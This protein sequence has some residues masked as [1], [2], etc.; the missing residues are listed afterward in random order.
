MQRDETP[1]C[2]PGEIAR[3]L[4][5]LIA[6]GAAFEIRILDARRRGRNWQPKVTFGYF[7]DP[8]QVAP[9]LSALQ[10]AAAKGVYITLNPIDSTLLARSYNRFTEAKTGTT[11]PDKYILSRRWLL[12]DFDPARPPDVSASVEE[13]D[14]AHQRCRAVYEALHAAGWPP[15]VVAD[16]GNGYHQLYRLDLPRDDDRV[17][18]CL[19]ALDLRFSDAAVDID[20]TVYNPSRILKLYG[21]K[22]MKGDDCPDLGRPHR[23]SRLLHIP[24]QLDPVPTTLLDA[25]A[26]EAIPEEQAEQAPARRPIARGRAGWDQARMEDF[27][28]R[29]LSH[30]DPYPVAPYDGG[31]KWVLRTCPFDPDHNDRSAVIVIRPNGALGFRCQHNGCQGKNWKA[32]R[33]RF[34]PKNEKTGRR[35]IPTVDTAEGDEDLAAQ[36]GPPILLNAGGV[37]TDI[38]QMFVAARFKRDNLIL[39][40]PHLAMFYAYDEP[41]GLWK[42]KTD[43]RVVVEMGDS[44]PSLLAAYDA[45]PLLR[46]RSEAFLGQLVRFLKGMVEKPDVFNRGAPIIYVGNGVLHLDENPPGIHPF[47][48]DYYSRNRSEIEYDPTATC[49]RFLDDLLRPALPEEDIFLLQRYAGMCLLGGNPAH[50]FL[51]LRGTAGGGKSTLVEI[52]ETVIG[53]HNVAQLRVHLLTERF[54]IAGF[55]GKTLLCGKDVPGNFLDNRAAHVIK[56]LTGGDRLSAEQKNVKHRFDVIGDFAIVIT[57]NTRLHV[58]LDSDTEAWRRRMLI[59]DFTQ[60]PS[61]KPIPYFAQELI[62]TEGPGILNWCVEGAVRLLDELRRFGHIQLTDIQKQRV[63][64]LLCES[65]SVRHFVTKCVA[66]APAGDVT[67][68]ELLTAYNDFCESQGWQ[69]V[70]VRQ[71]ESQVCDHMIAIHHVPKRTDIRRNDKNQRGYARVALQDGSDTAPSPAP[72]QPELVPF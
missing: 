51:V 44:L 70:T 63:D 45:A 40:E 65:D 15:P 22:A 26:G 21:T 38:N 33:A 5:V 10:L 54:E 39:H 16:S 48:P 17:R 28:H 69:A 35:E 11:T 46:K 72:A 24:G 71:F 3:A 25:L 20:T 14:A 8:A 41:T 6:P 1:L 55:L 59:I 29:H 12:V 50:R 61:A 64:A 19:Q 37:P 58:Q 34:E 7:D 9:A 68:A 30:C 66:A 52:I 23:M 18:R 47:S 67:V 32:L 60:P 13:K 56:P 31:F 49:P 43:S 2:E 62:R 57:T 53:P 42:P 36:Y 4:A 27:I